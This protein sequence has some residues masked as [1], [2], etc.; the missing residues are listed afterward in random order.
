MRI[1]G[2]GRLTDNNIK[3]LTKYYGKAIESNIDD[4]D[5]IKRCCMGNILPFTVHR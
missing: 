5:A 2:K 1:K 4:S 3:K